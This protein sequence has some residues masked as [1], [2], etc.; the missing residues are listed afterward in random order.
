MMARILCGSLCL[1]LLLIASTQAQQ[2][3][4]KSMKSDSKVVRASAQ[5]GAGAAAPRVTR[6]EGERVRPEEAM[7][8]TRSRL[9]EDGPAVA[10]MSALQEN[11]STVRNNMNTY[12]L[13][14][15]LMSQKVGE[16][17]VFTGPVKCWRAASTG[18]VS[19]W[20]PMT[21]PASREETIRRAML[22]EPIVQAEPIDE[23]NNLRVYYLPSLVGHDGRQYQVIPT[24]IAFFIHP[25][26]GHRMTVITRD[27]RTY[28]TVNKPL[29]VTSN[30]YVQ[31]TKSYN[32]GP[33]GLGTAHVP[34]VFYSK[35]VQFDME[36]FAQGDTFETLMHTVLSAKERGLLSTDDFNALYA[37]MMRY[38]G[39]KTE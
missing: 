25:K 26:T 13:G 33:L 3:K 35:R 28:G 37:E 39:G 34:Y 9:I 38:T 17:H 5:E 36:P 20:P 11:I 15:S 10:R 14:Y 2:S 29:A 22:L 8:F 21:Y 31:D 6:I 30:I 1:S 24:A 16:R 27:G 18:D 23:M 19:E 12:R 7:I 32:V 4:S